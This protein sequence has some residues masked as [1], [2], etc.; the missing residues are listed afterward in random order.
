MFDDG[1]KKRRQPRGKEEAGEFAMEIEECFLEDV[2]GVIF[3]A[4]KA[5]GEAGHPVAI[6][7]VKRVEGGRFAAI[8]GRYQLLVAT[9]V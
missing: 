1:I 4:A 7:V 6:T 8:Q 2:E 5:L 9:G 3:I